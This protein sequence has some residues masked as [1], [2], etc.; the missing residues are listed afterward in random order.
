MVSW[1]QTDLPRLCNTNAAPIMVRQREGEVLVVPAM[2][3]HA[4][5]NL[6]PTLAFSA[7]MGTPRLSAGGAAILAEALH[8]EL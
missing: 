8:Q 7:Q 5:V 2:W 3:T 1:V 6:A 4:V